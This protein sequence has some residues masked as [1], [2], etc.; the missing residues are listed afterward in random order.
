MQQ[1]GT[2]PAGKRPP[3]KT[4]CWKPDN[5]QARTPLSRVALDIRVRH[6]VAMKL[7]PA[8]LSGFPRPTSAPQRRV[9]Y[10]NYF[11]RLQRQKR[12]HD[13]SSSGA[14]LRRRLG[15][16]GYFLSRPTQL[17]AAL[18]TLVIMTHM[19]SRFLSDFERILPP[20][21]VTFND[22]LSRFGHLK[23]QPILTQNRQTV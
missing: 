8:L 10:E 16:G 23:H 6:P 11:G 18:H 17:R 21:A 3:L 22:I 13:L 5:R 7:A 14:C 9:Q 20:F 15:G 1:P 2:L 4:G 12:L 19:Q